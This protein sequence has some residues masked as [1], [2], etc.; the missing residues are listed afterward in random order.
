MVEDDRERVVAITSQ[1][2]NIPKAMR[3]HAQTIPAA[4]IRVAEDRGRVMASLRLRR[5]AQFYGGRSVPALGI[6]AVAVDPEA[7][8]R[9]VAETLMVTTLREL[10][11]EMPISIL[12]PATVP[13]YRR[14]GYEYAAPWTD[15]KAPLERLPRASSLECER[16]D[17]DALDEIAACYREAASAANGPLDRPRGWW[18]DSVFRV[19]EDEIQ[20]FCVREDGRVTGYVVYTQQK[21]KLK[22]WGYDLICRDLVWTTPGAARGLLAFLGRH[23]SLG[24]NGVW[25]GPPI[26]EL[27]WLLDEQEAVIDRSFLSM[28]RLADVPAAFEARG[29]PPHVRAAVELD[30]RDDAIPENAGVW[31]IEVADGA[32]KVVPGGGTSN[33]ADVRTVAALWTGALAPGNAVRAGWL[34]ADSD[35]VAALEAMLAGPPPWMSDW[36]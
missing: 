32:A 7:R 21:P 22:D 1:A 15:Y 6:G 19:F 30:V 18:S 4:D 8:G 24:D 10:R 13:L 9:R 27:A 5:V 2:F 20:R 12:Y 3:E 11:S 29:Y 28:A 23:R 34:A 25:H 36:F 33:A 31:R 16:W 26:D 17:D 14:C 35:A